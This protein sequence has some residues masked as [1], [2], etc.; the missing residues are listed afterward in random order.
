MGGGIANNGI[1]II[2]KETQGISTMPD[3][4]LAKTW[5]NTEGQ[6]NELRGDDFSFELKG[7]QVADE[8]GQA[9][10]NAERKH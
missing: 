9:I 3:I 2:G 1:L 10:E 8:N 6:Q 5:L 7:G 4:F